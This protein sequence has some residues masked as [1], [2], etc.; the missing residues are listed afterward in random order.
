MENNDK[1]KMTAI[2][3]IGIISALT[4][5]TIITPVI[6]LVLIYSLVTGRDIE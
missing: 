1:N 2:I 3:V 4:F 6:G 5:W